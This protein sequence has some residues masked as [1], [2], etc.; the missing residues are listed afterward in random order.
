MNHL[1]HI[2]YD[3]YVEFYENP[4]QDVSRDEV[5]NWVAHTDREVQDYVLQAVELAIR[6]RQSRVPKFSE[7]G[8]YRKLT[9]LEREIRQERVE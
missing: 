1:R 2:A 6:Q 8:L 5:E 9:P 7:Q 4:R 3:K